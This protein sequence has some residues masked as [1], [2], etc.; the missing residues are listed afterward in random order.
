MIWFL[1]LLFG[2]LFVVITGT[3]IWASL[4]NAIW[5]IPP[6]VLRDAWFRAT[7]VDIYISF[8]T[9]FVWVCYQERSHVA[10]VMWGI[11]IAGLGSIAIT[12][13]VLRALF[14]VEPGA[15][16]EDVLVRRRSMRE[17]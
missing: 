4:D 3:V 15:T 5:N 11:A 9:F 13:Y 7:L 10:R 1:R 12:A 8:T 16:I 6:A 2:V 14:R 17:D